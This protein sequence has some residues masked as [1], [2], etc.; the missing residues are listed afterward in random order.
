MYGVSLGPELRTPDV[1]AFARLIGVNRT[2]FLE[3][4]QSEPYLD[5]NYTFPIDLAPNGIAFG[6]KSTPEECIIIVITFQI[7]FGPTRFGK[8]FSPCVEIAAQDW[9]EEQR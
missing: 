1:D 9:V 5:C 3:F 4:S 7:W 8:Y 6:A 2:I